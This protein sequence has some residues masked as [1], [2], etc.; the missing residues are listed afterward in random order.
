L[1][2]EAVVFGDYQRFA[3]ESDGVSP[4]VIPGVA[5]G[6]HLAAGSEH[7]PSGTITENAANRTHMMNKR[8]GKLDAMRADLPRA[9]V[10]GDP[11]ADIVLFGYGSNRGPIV[12]TVDRL[13]RAGIPVRFFEFR[14]LWPFPE[15]DVR[16]FVADAKAIFVIEN[17][18]TGQ[19]ERLVRYVVGPL[20]HMHL[21]NKYD[22]R[23]FRP[24]EIE[25]AIAQHVALRAPAMPE[26][27]RTKGSL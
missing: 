1:L 3:L 16:A 26:P 20:P 27:V 18:Y 11:A 6:M 25:R 12:E 9:I 19:L 17:N 21:V 22:G 10:H 23:P 13:A 15:D 14:T 4:R 2:T 7:D 8:M 24:I 5:G